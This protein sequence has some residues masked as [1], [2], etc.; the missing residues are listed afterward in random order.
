MSGEVPGEPCPIADK[1]ANSQ[2]AIL[3]THSG[4]N[5]LIVV[6][7][8]VILTV[9]PLFLPVEWSKA[10]FIAGPIVQMATL[11][12]GLW[13]RKSTIRHRWC[14]T[15]AM[16]IAGIEA[17]IGGGLLAFGYYMISSYRGC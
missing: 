2:E 10:G 11:Y 8:G 15:L 13:I 12:E 4:L 3:E 17:V 9:A 16:W 1:V 5:F 14:F 6:L 7:I